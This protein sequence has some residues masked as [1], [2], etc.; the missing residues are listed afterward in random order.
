MRWAETDNPVRRDFHL[1][2][3]SGIAALAPFL[4]DNT[5][6]PDAAQDAPFALGKPLRQAVQEG[7]HNTPCALPGQAM[8]DG[9]DTDEFTLRH[10]VFPPLLFENPTLVGAAFV[11]AP[12]LL[13][14]HEP[15]AL[16]IGKEFLEAGEIE[17]LLPGA[18][19][20]LQ[21]MVQVHR[22][23]RVVRRV[24]QAIGSALFL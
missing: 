21:K 16:G 13:V 1:F 15:M 17:N 2:P 14:L 9:H 8:T 7:A 22:D 23:E 19:G 6:R 24:V 4:L 10:A 20:Y 3:R 18:P 12:Y 11:F 5:Q